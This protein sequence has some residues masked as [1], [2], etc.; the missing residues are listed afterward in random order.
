[1]H[2]AHGPLALGLFQIFVESLKSSYIIKAY[3]AGLGEYVC[4]VRFINS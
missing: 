3:E 4:L 1:M 2:C